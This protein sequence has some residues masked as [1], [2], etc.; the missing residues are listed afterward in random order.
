MENW[1]MAEPGGK[2]S[3][4]IREYVG[5]TTTG[6]ILVVVARRCFL[7]AEDTGMQWTV[8]NGTL[9]TLTTDAVE[10]YSQGEEDGA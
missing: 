3:Y 10:A 8:R 5:C 9:L 4:L 6:R 1:V 7:T 2:K